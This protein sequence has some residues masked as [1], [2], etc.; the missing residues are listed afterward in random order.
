MTEYHDNCGG[1]ILIGGNVGEDRHQYCDRCGAYAY[2][3]NATL[4]TGTDEKA[5][6]QA[7][8]AGD[9]ESP[10]GGEVIS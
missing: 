3:I 10:R 1:T 6:Q 5:N 8:D 9:S 7:W 4:P 2:K